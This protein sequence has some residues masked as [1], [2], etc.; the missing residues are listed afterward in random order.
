MRTKYTREL[1]EPI[2]KR[3]RSFAQVIRELD[4]VYT[5]GTYGHIKRIVLFHGIG[6]DH[7][8]GRGNN[9]GDWHCGGPDR[10]TAKEILILKGRTSRPT[11][12]SQLKRALLE[13]GRPYRC[14]VCKLGSEWNGKSL[15]L[16]ID[17]R[18]GRRWDSRPSNVRFICPNCHSQTENFGGKNKI[19][20]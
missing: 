5:G 19:R 16:Q 14:E 7:F 17:H 9:R 1:L 18:N 3:S 12:A 2:V 15:S 10:K 6:T 13:I 8:F 4:L 11:S 20:N